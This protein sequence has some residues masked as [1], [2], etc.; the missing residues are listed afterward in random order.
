[1]LFRSASSIT[2]DRD[3]N[4]ICA[5]ENITLTINGGVLG[6]GATWKW[7]TG[8]CGGTALPAFN[9]QT[10]ISVSP[11]ATTTYFAR[12]EGQCNISACAS[13]TVVVSSGNGPVGGVTYSYIPV[14]AA[15]GVTDSL[16]V[17]PVAGATY[18][19][20]YTINGHVNSVLFNGSIG[21]VQTG[22][23]RVNVSF[24]LPEQNYQLRCVAGNACG[25]TQPSSTT[26][27]GTVAAPTCLNG[28]T[29]V[30][31]GQTA[32]YTVCAIPSQTSVTYDWQ[33][34][35]SNA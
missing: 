30:C 22:T 17:V 29:Q 12:A 1:M 10:T 27:R 4:N 33:L 6:A 16:V 5:G 31:P 13:I 25:R 14:N 32:S 26:V 28:P 20:W 19:R 24:V 2:S 23:N 7:Y 3:Y 21:P 9:G 11:A 35:P 8:S 18:Y 34:T 15:P